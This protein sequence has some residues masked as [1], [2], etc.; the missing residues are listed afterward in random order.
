MPLRSSRRGGWWVVV[1]L[2]GEGDE[3]IGHPP[4]LGVKLL[5]LGSVCKE[6]FGFYVADVFEKVIGRYWK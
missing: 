2:P 1:D 3:T 6:N 4:F 5:V